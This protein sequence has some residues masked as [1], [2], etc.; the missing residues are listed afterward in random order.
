MAHPRTT[1][2]ELQWEGGKFMATNDFILQRVD[3]TGG[4]TAFTWSATATTANVVNPIYFPAGTATAGTAP[5]YLQSGTLLSVSVIGAT[6]FLT[7]KLYFTIT[8]GTAR[9]EI[10]L[11]DAALTSGR[12]LFATTNG[13]LVDSS[14]LTYT[15]VTGLQVIAGA[16]TAVPVIAKGASSQTADLFQAQDTS[17][18]ILSKVDVNG[19]GY[20][21]GTGQSII[22]TGMV[23]NQ[24][25]DTTTNG[26]FA[27]NGSAG[28][29]IQATPSTNTI[30]LGLL[31]TYNSIATVRNGLQV[32]YA[33]VDLTAQTA[34]IGATTVYAVPA[35]GVGMYRVCWVATVTTAA[36]TSS[37]LGGTNGFQ[38]KYTDGDDSVVKTSVAGATS[39]A[40]TTATTLSGAIV[41]Y[42]KASTNIQYSMGYTSV[43]TAMA[44]NLH[45]TVSKI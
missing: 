36:G 10:A 37:I 40:N 42:A 35:S 45:V 43:G 15:A 23:I 11:L 1:G 22:Q 44:F 33:K 2:A 26:I 19:S 39:A 13:R 38:V 24:S 9:K 3:A 31:D 12:V 41:V 8:T 20:F 25:L 34:A 6:E 17:A 29:L 5:I 28:Y 27:A 7:D 14:N 30:Q 4:F 18:N 16:P 21:S 32:S